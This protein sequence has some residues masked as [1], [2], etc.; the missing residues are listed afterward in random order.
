MITERLRSIIAGH[1]HLTNVNCARIPVQA[2][3]VIVSYNGIN[4]LQACINSILE[5]IHPEDEIILVDNASTDGSADLVREHHPR[6]RLL[7]NSTN[8]GFAVAC[9]QG[10][11]YAGGENLIFLNQDTR[12]QPGWLAALLAPLEQD[13]AVGLVTS[14]I[15]LMARPD[16]IHMCGQEIHFTGFSFGR[17]FLAPADGYTTPQQV[18]AAS[19]ASFAIRRNLWEQLGGFDPQLFMYYE[20]TDLSWRARL[21]GCASLYVPDS[22]VFHDFA[23]RDSQLAHI[24]SERNRLVLILKNWKWETLVLLTPSLLLAEVIDWGYMLSVG[25][26]GIQAKL[27]ACGWLMR[28]CANVVSAR[29]NVQRSRRE[30]DWVLLK[31]CTDHLT[32]RLHTGGWLGQ[33]VIALCNLWFSMHYRVSLSLMRKLD[34]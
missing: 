22:I 31:T 14:K 26:K 5:E 27:K 25:W 33:A 10:A 2:S 21:V 34:I 3:I 16:Q 24:F 18:G 8:L 6:V 17:G 29:K 11:S 20:E 13:P 28:N 23:L 15:L 12:V 32:P 4:Y 19:G 30:P 1:S 9:N 7:D